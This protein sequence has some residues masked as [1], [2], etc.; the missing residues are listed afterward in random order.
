MGCDD[1]DG[2]L[3]LR[4]DFG[5]DSLCVCVRARVCICLSVS[6]SLLCAHTRHT[7]HIYTHPHPHQSAPIKPTHMHTTIL[8]SRTL[9][10]IIHW[11][12]FSISNPKRN[13]TLCARFSCTVKESTEMSKLLISGDICDE[14]GKGGF[15]CSWLWTSACVKY[16]YIYLFCPHAIPIS[17]CVRNM[18]A[19]IKAWESVYECAV[20]VIRSAESWDVRE[21]VWV[22]AA[23]A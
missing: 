9:R 23:L 12:R 21:W 17:T 13:P 7:N 22:S 1:D 14:C 11:W 8:Y 19:D 3:M 5:K 4:T 15:V 16:M 18:G 6:L 2:G 10:L 20:N